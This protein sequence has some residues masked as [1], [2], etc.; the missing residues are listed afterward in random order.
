MQAN[1]PDGDVKG[2]TAVIIPFTMIEKFQGESD[3]AARRRVHVE[4]SAYR[5]A[6]GRMVS[7]TKH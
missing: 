7:A 5:K 3:E 2:G 1:M 6:D 4:S